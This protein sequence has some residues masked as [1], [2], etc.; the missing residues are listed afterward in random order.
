MHSKQGRKKRGAKSN[1]SRE[2][3]P[4]DKWTNVQQ[5]YYKLERRMSLES[6]AKQYCVYIGRKKKYSLFTLHV[7][8]FDQTK[9]SQADNENE[10]RGWGNVNARVSI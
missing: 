9:Y 5:F 6:K 2:L 4:N 3:D 10:K 7:L 1:G 8:R